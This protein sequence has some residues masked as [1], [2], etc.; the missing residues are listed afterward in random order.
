MKRNSYMLVRAD[1]RLRQG[2]RWRF[3]FVMRLRT[4]KPYFFHSM[5]KAEIA[6]L[7]RRLAR[8]GVVVFGHWRFTRLGRGARL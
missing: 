8:K 6:L 2:A 3:E 5:P 7:G 4:L 1:S